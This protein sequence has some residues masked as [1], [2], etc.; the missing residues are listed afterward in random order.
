[1]AGNIWEWT[2]DWFAA[3]AYELMKPQNPQ[4]PDSGDCKVLRGGS[5]YNFTGVLR[6]ADRF[7]DTPVHRGN[8]IGFR[9]VVA[10]QKTSK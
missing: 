4:G 7:Y 2:N 8:D 9:C 1:M 5:W 10:S 3:D 6:A